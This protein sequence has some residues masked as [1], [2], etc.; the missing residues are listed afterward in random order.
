MNRDRPCRRAARARTA[1][2]LLLA[3]GL[4]SEVALSGWLERDARVRDPEYGRKLASF[5]RLRRPQPHRPVVLA[6]GSSRVCMGVCP[7]PSAKA[8]VPEAVPPN[9]PAR[10]ILFNFGLIGSGPLMELFCLRRLLADGVR[11]DALLVEF[12]P[13]FLFEQDEQCE[14]RRLYVSRL[15]RAD[16]DLLSRYSEDAGR[17]A[18]RWRQARLVP[19]FGHRFALLSELAP[20]WLPAGSRCDFTWGDLD[21][22]GWLPEYEERMDPELRRQLLASSVRPFY[23]RIYA[24][25][26]VSPVADRAWHELLDLCRREGIPVTILRLPEAGEFRAW[27]PPDV[28][29]RS[30]AFLAELRREFAPGLVDARDWQPD[31]DLPDAFHLCAEGAAR[32]TARL[33]REVVP[34]LVRKRGQR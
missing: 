5:R 13:P 28:T 27:Y 12:W 3:L 26:E 24:R 18:E 21:E 11:P 31:A 20:G 15:C 33:Q 7:Q 4:G 1:V 9:D 19:C 32:F 34:G 14:E 29:T 10:P 2:L 23:D 22:W 25:F 16:I 6:L 30:E 17:L 8:T